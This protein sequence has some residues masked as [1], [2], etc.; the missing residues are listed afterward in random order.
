MNK[1]ERMEAWEVRKTQYANQ[2]KIGL[3]GACGEDPL[4]E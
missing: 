1:E 2:W 4:C 3:M